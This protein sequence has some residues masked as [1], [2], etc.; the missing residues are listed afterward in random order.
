MCET[1]AKGNTFNTDMFLHG[2]FHKCGG[3]W[4]RFLVAEGKNTFF[5]AWLLDNSMPLLAHTEI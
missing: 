3:Q 1:E 4:S 5:H 2:A